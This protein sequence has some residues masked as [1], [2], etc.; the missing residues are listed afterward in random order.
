MGSRVSSFDS[1]KSTS[2]YLGGK[3]RREYSFENGKEP[4]CCSSEF[5]LSRVRDMLLVFQPTL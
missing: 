2:R 1:T 3:P 4:V 5:I